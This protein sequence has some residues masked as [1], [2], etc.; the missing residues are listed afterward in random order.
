ME[1]LK[2]PEELPQY[3]LV[4]LPELP[5]VLESEELQDQELVAAAV[6]ADIMAEAAGHGPEVAADQAMLREFA[7]V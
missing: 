2:L 6:A 1:V 5:A 7:Q 3:I 4:I